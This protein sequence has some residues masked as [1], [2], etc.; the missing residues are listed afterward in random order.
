[1]RHQVIEI[2]EVQAFVR[3]FVRYGRRCP[4]C[5]KI[6]YAQLPVGVPHHIVGPRLQAMLAA[7][8]GRFRV[9]RPEAIELL[10]DF[11][12][13]KARL[14][15]GE[16]SQ[17]EEETSQVLKAPYE[18]AKQYMSREPVAHCDETKWGRYGWLWVMVAGVV[19][20][21]MVHKR[22]AREAFYQIVGAF[23]GILVTD[24]FGVY[25]C[26]DVLKRALCW[27]HL[28]R[29]FQALVDRGGAGAEVGKVLLGL[30]DR[31]FAIWKE[32]A[33][34][35][36]SREELQRRMAS[37]Q[38]EME[39]MLAWGSESEDP[40]A[41]ALC[42][43][44][45]ELFPAL[46]TFVRIEGVPPTNNTA[47]LM[48]RPAVLWRHVAHGCQ[49]DRGARFCERIL[50][51]AATLRRQ[52]RSVLGYLEQAIRAWRMGQPTPSLVP[53]PNG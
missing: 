23:A 11:F 45:L 34:G 22:R 10:V 53:V 51:V 36:F 31:V 30:K 52:G 7:L 27:A 4:R 37:I 32:F 2:P 8:T 5:G 28:S 38:E 40:K 21:F 17:L 13:Q 39:W 49:S 29:N 42:L 43:D 24:R 46:W 3:E 12:G 47:E 1:M 26:V 35:M 48:I 20:L 15:V 9:S 19:T 50:T 25:L 33:A 16:V 14:S 6:T 44:L 18:E 41:A